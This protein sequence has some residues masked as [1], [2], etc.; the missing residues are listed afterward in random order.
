MFGH[1]I[2]TTAA[3]AAR[4]TAAIL[5]IIGIAWLSPISPADTAT[6]AGSVVFL[7]D[8]RGHGSGV[9]IGNGYILTAAHVVRDETTMDVTTDTGETVK[10]TVLWANKAHDVAMVRAE[11]DAKASHLSCREPTAG[12]EIVIAGNPND[13]KFINAYGR[14][15]GESR[16]YGPWKRVFIADA[17][18]IPGVSGGPTF[19]AKGDVIGINVGVMLV[20][21]GISASI[22]RLG[23]VV[24]GAVVCMLMARSA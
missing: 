7:G 23:Y 16:E 10:G 18:I 5:I 3:L 22:A 21:T 13:Q 24:P 11:V 8:A 1:T 6:P 15:G 19:D 2:S 20:Q 17:T 12:E 4:I 9:H 14:V